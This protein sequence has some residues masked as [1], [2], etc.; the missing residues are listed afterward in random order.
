MQARKVFLLTIALFLC[1]NVAA[2]AELRVSP[3]MEL[4]GGVQTQTR[5]IKDRGPAGQGN[6]YFQ[7]L[8]DFFA[9]YADHRAIKLADQFTKNAFTYDAPPAF[10]CHL[11]PLP[12]LELRYEYSDYL[13]ERARGRDKLEEFRIA[14]R[15]L[16]AETDFLSFYAVWE[17]YL[18]ASIAESKVGFRQDDIEQWLTEFFGWPAAEF[19]LFMT[20]SMFPG[21]GYGATVTDSDGSLVAFQIIRDS[22][23]GVHPDFPSGI[24]LENLTIHELGHSFVNPSMEVYPDRAKA[25]RP[26]YWPVRGAMRQ[27][28]Y[29]NVEI[30]LNEQVL[31]AVEVIAARDLFNPEYEAMIL[32][33]NEERSFYLT[34]YVVEQL[35]YYQANREQ[36]HRFTDFVPYLYDQLDVYQA[37]NSSWID[38]IFGFFL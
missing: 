13:V 22:G 2:L 14:L 16:A 38:H 29:P 3:E 37:E 21:G 6:E 8:S 11:G 1:V 33:S 12:E 18:E 31:R 30:F 26:L 9:Q 17:P 23:R 10:I 36:Y 15:D 35:E 4:L 5:W 28:A 20:P 19:H 32:T 24:S 25:L 27:Q 7:A 34:S